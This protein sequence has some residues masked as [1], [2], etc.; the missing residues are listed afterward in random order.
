MAPTLGDAVLMPNTSVIVSSDCDHTFFKNLFPKMSVMQLQ[1]RGI[2]KEPT[3]MKTMAHDCPAGLHRSCCFQIRFTLANFKKYL[4]N[5]LI[6]D[7]CSSTDR[8]RQDCY[9]SSWQVLTEYVSVNTFY[10]NYIQ[11]IDIWQIVS[12]SKI[13]WT[14]AILL[15]SHLLIDGLTLLILGLYKWPHLNCTA[16]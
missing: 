2:I 8:H 6:G 15:F 14:E 9:K 13:I 12:N 4:Y 1:G 16:L 7:D 5:N 11:V 3:A 10:C